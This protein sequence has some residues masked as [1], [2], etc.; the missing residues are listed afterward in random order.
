[1]CIC[2][3]TQNTMSRIARRFVRTVAQSCAKSCAESCAESCAKLDRTLRSQSCAKLCAES[4]AEM[5][6]QCA[7]LFISARRSAGL[8]SLARMNCTTKAISAH[9]RHNFGTIRHTDR[10]FR[11][12]IRH[13]DRKF[14]HTIRH[15]IRTIRHTIRHTIWA[16]MLLSNIPEQRWRKLP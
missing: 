1:M 11:H 4:C 10:K 12:T 6:G 3:P 7:E 13:T 14:R 15:A 8:R 16:M 9:F 5:L 2:L